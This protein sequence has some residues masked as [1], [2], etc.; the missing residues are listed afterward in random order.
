MSMARPNQYREQDGHVM[1]HPHIQWMWDQRA[2]R[3]WDGYNV[4]AAWRQAEPVVTPNTSGAAYARLHV[5]AAMILVA[6][7]GFL[8]TAIDFHEC[9]RGVQAQI[10]DQLDVTLVDLG[11]DDD[12]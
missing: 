2:R 8:T 10:V 5:E 3:E 4:R 7:W 1:A 11:V 6:K 9:S 12:E